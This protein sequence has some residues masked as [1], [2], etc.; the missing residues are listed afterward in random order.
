M[1]GLYL[2]I[3]FCEHKCSYCDF[4]SIEKA[5]DYDSFVV[6]L[7]EDIS[8]RCGQFHRLCSQ[9]VTSVFFGGGTPSL[10][11][12]RQVQ[13]ILHTLQEYCGFSPAAEITL[14]CNPNTVT[15]ALLAQYRS[16]GINRLSFGV[17]SFVPAELAFLQRTHSPEQAKQAMTSARDAGF[18]NVNMDLMFALPPQTEESL[19]YS[20]EQ[21]VQLQPNHISAYSLTVEHGT[22]LYTQ[23]QRG[24][25]RTHSEELDA[26]MFERMSSLLRL[27]N[28]HQYEVS[29]FAQSGF[30]CLHNSTYW[31]AGNYL[32]FGPSA[33]GYAEGYRYWNTKNLQRYTAQVA[34]RTLPTS[35]GEQLTIQQ[36]FEEYLFLQLRSTGIDF[37]SV[38]NRFGVDIQP[39]IA[40]Q[41]RQWFAAGFIE[42]NPNTITL[43]AEGYRVCDE[44][45]L[46]LL[47][48]TER[49][50][51]VPPGLHS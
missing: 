42:N 8:M 26:S 51:L 37:A 31:N 46:R 12:A 28:Y 10:L 23:V 35:N 44:I 3:P 6:T 2:H 14:E 30:R 32:A 34:S 21:M 24:L 5:W 13:K 45:T 47:D 36:Q 39:T 25:V 49:L 29:N 11:S 22:P 38:A 48:A 15:T 17:Q 50:Q 27:A 16:I 33:H 9:P 1:F 40:P 41:H 19:E 20:V 4:Y 7:C 18:E 43:T